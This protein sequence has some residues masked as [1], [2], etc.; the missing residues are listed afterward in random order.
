MGT[1]GAFEERLPARLHGW[2]EDAVAGGATLLCGGGRE[3][4]MLEATLAIKRAGADMI[5]TYFAKS[6]AKVLNRRR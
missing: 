4:A 1:A 5:L 6:L 2:I 3:G